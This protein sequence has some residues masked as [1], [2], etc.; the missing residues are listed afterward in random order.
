MESID[1]SDTR[2][3][4]WA[5]IVRTSDS[6]IL[7]NRSSNATIMRSPPGLCLPPVQPSPAGNPAPVGYGLI[8][9][10]NVHAPNLNLP[11][12][13]HLSNH[14]HSRPCSPHLCPSTPSNH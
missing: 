5:L 4:Y 9:P 7:S 6:T 8:R 10:E 14:L 1:S 2:P 3:R 11:F 13:T 12:A